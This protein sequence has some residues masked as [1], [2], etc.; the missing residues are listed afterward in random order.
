MIDVDACQHQAEALERQADALEAVATEL[1][2]QNAVL[3]EIVAS[4]VEIV[5]S[6]DDLSAR[7]DDR[8]TEGPPPDRSGRALQT[9]IRD[10][11]FERDELEDDVA[12]FR[13]GRPENWRGRAER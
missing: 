13:W 9:W 7:V 12:E 1:R 5:A 4:L 10:R 11:L 8:P 2:Y 3:V 6:M